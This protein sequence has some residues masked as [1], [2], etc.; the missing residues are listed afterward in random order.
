MARKC[1]LF[2]WRRLCIW[3]HMWNFTYC[4]SYYH[5]IFSPFPLSLECTA[6]LVFPSWGGPNFWFRLPPPGR[7]RISFSLFKVIPWP[8]DTIPCIYPFFL[9]IFFIFLAFFWS[10]PRSIYFELSNFCFLR[11]AALLSRI[12]IFSHLFSFSIYHFSGHF[13]YLT[14]TIG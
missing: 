5:L 8:A 2:R 3:F 12:Q 7:Y 13:R 6:I 4:Y 14:C 11:R 1:W 9:W 10:Y